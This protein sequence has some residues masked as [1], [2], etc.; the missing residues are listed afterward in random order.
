MNL[1]AIHSKLRS[2]YTADRHRAA[3][4]WVLGVIYFTIVL[5]MQFV[6]DLPADTGRYVINGSLL[7]VGLMLLLPPPGGFVTVFLGEED[8]A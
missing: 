6:E 3:Y 7:I 4:R 2:T 1:R 5:T 8:Q